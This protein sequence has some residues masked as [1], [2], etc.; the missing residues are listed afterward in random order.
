MVR[1]RLQRKTFY[2]RF[3]TAGVDVQGQIGDDFLTTYIFRKDG[4]A[5]IEG[6]AWIAEAALIGEEG[7]SY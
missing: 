4:V 6:V 2:F 5:K 1:T 7:K 3:L